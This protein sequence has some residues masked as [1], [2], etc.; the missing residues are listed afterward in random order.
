M[1]AHH[2]DTLAFR[3]KRFLLVEQP[4]EAYFELIGQRPRLHGGGCADGRGYAARWEIRDGW[5]YLAGLA[6]Q[7]ADNSPVAL[8]NLFPFAGERIFATWFS[9]TLH[10]FRQDDAEQ[11]CG[12]APRRYPDLVLTVDQGR[13]RSSSIVH[14]GAPSAVDAH[15][16]A[17]LQ[18]G[19]EAMAS[20]AGGSGLMI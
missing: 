8:Q 9:G 17:G 13:V 19:R 6:G 5:L 11:G 14:R 18:A 12:A 10:A 16:E 1:S 3:D 7:W 4:L 2:G 20:A 15:A